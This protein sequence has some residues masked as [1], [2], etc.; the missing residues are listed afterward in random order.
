MQ[1][2]MWAAT[3]EPRGVHWRR[4]L[5]AQR[6]GRPYVSGAPKPASH[7]LATRAPA[8]TL[9]RQSACR[10]YYYIWYLSQLQK[11]HHTVFKGQKCGFLLRQILRVCEFSRETARNFSNNVKKIVMKNATSNLLH[12]ISYCTKYWKYCQAKTTNA[13]NLTYEENVMNLCSLH[14]VFN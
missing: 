1:A 3:M 10:M 8:L 9:P 12:Y 7:P 6:C 2:S 4:R 11:Q 5:A 13:I 14:F